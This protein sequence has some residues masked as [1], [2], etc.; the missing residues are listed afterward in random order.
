MSK[1]KKKKKQAKSIFFPDAE[2]TEGNGTYEL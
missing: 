1:K 2:N